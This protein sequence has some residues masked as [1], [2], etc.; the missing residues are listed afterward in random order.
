MQDIQD[1]ERQKRKKFGD[2][3]FE[4]S[5]RVHSFEGNE[6]DEYMGRF[7]DVYSSEFRHYYL[8]IFSVITQ[9][10]LGDAPG[11]AEILLQNVESLCKIC[12]D[13]NLNSCE[14]KTDVSVLTKQL[15]E[16][17][18]HISLEMARIQFMESGY[19]SSE[20]GVK[21]CKLE[22]N[23]RSL[24]NKTTVFDNK[25]RQ[26]EHKAAEILQ[27]TQR[28]YVTI[29]GIFA[30]VVMTCMGTVAFSSSVLSN[31][32]NASIYRITLSIL[33]IGFVALNLFFALFHYL[34]KVISKGSEDLGF[35]S[36]WRC[37]NRII[38]VLVAL[39]CLAWLF[40]V[41]E[42]R[43]ECVVSI[44]DIIYKILH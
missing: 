6:Y 17:Y 5:Y 24:E 22:D 3:L 14:P 42:K 12:G 34:D 38:C 13:P 16:L 28:D 25:M 20:I 27:Q 15:H 18:D 23:I 19:Q 33:L 7:A 26:K 4:L 21:V 32:H 29:L 31:I 9:L 1:F 41:V 37:T 40:R 39:V 43:D 35:R 30:T 44:Y 10:K 11:D 8:D 36:L 2:I